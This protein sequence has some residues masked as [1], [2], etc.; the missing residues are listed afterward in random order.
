MK[1]TE[2]WPDKETCRARSRRV[3]SAGQRLCQRSWGTPS[4]WHVDGF[5]SESHT[6]RVLFMEALLLRHDWL[7]TPFP[8]PLWRFGGGAKNFLKIIYVSGC[9]RSCCSGQA[10]VYPSLSVAYRI[11]VPCRFLTSVPVGKFWGWKLKFLIMVFLSDD[12]S[13]S[14][15]HLIRTKYNVVIHET[16]R[17][18]GCLSG[19]RV[20]KTNTRIQDS[21]SVLI[22]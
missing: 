18:L 17:D 2:K 12:Q 15:S 21:P 20:K 13:L 6:I 11:F 1:D 19:I 22:T 4:S 9:L 8:A 16:P 14:E 5:I 7:L 3:P 10:L